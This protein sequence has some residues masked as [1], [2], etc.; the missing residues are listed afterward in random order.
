MLK[1]IAAANLILTSVFVLSGCFNFADEEQPQD[2]AP[3]TSSSYETNEFSIST[4]SDWEVIDQNDF[5]ADVPPETLVVFRNNVKNETYTANVNIVKREL[6]ESVDSLEYANLVANREKSGLVDY[7]ENRKDTIA[8]Q[9]PD[10]EI[11]TYLTVFQ[12]RKTSNDQM[13]RY[14]Q[15]YIARGNAAYIITGSTSLQ[16]TETTSQTVENIVRSFQIR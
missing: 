2:L 6:Q 15:T 10:G 9:G 3:G 5:T 7:S 8:L 11:Q 13:I 1:K 12:A 14:Y 16:E 4:P